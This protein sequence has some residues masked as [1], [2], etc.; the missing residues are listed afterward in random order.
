MEIVEI[1]CV[2]VDCH[3]PERVATFWAEALHWPDA[4]VAADGGGALC[5]PRQ[6]GMYLEFIHV[7]EGKVVKNRVHLGCRVDA[8][9]DLELEIERL[10]SLGA[11]I[12]W[13]EEF[14]P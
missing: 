4:A 13:E 7:P 1:S 6:G 5:G 2:T 12:A 14:P 9:E 8:L 3:D 11:V 10:R